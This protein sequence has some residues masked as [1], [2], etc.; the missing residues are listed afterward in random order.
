[1]LKLFLNENSNE[2]YFIRM[3]LQNKNF[4]YIF[5]LFRKLN[6]EISNDYT[7]KNE[8]ILIR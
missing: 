8:I 3:E 1:M 6:F 7:T 5:K 2:K 4:S